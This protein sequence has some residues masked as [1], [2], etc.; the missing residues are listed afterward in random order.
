MS[1][2]LSLAGCGP[3]TLFSLMPSSVDP[4]AEWRMIFL[5][6]KKQGPV[7]K[8]PVNVSWKCRFL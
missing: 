7:C 2:G 6:G 8:I 1:D 5:E 3:W 4:C